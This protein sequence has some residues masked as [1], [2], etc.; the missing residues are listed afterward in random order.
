MEVPTKTKTGKI[1]HKCILLRESYREDGKVKNRTIANLTNC[2]A[3]E[4]E[5]IRLALKLKLDRWLKVEAD[6]RRLELREEI[7]KK[8]EEAKQDG[9]YVIKSDLPMEIDKEKI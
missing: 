9:C 6:G 7:D 4:I 3:N 2:K 1:S 5:A 8:E